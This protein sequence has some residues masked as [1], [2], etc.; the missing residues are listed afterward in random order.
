V[1]I[2]ATETALLITGP[3]GR[4]SS[5]IITEFS[6]NA[7]TLDMSL[8]N[9]AGLAAIEADTGYTLTLSGFAR[10]LDAFPEDPILFPYNVISRTIRHLLPNGRAWRATLDKPLRRFF[11]GL[12][13]S[14]IDFRANFDAVA[15]DLY[16]AT[17]RILSEYEEQFG[18][19][20]STL[21]TQER[22]DRIDAA[23][24]ARGGQSPRYIQDTLQAAGFNVFVHNWW[25]PGT[26]N[27]RDP[28][29]VLGDSTTTSGFNVV[30]DGT[31]AFT[32]NPN[33]VT[34]AAN[35]PNGYLLVNLPT[36]TEYLIPT[37][38]GLW[39]YI[40]YIGGDV[41]GNRASIPSA[42][43]DEFETLCLKIC[44]LQLWIGVIVEYS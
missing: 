17:T 41:W 15:E 12:G 39:P 25:Q 16:P 31:I 29:D 2:S 19:Y 11:A 13:D 10:T 18:L 32:N 43:R 3:E 36:S 28:F 42:R 33:A 7:E 30:S 8:A 35:A 4:I 44:P 6:G 24:K 21:S 22:R 1:T 20:P 23:W 40:I 5:V 14:L 38:S 9:S 26:T 34:G 27:A 37:N